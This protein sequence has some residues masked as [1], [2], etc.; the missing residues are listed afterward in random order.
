MSRRF[1]LAATLAVLL[2]ACLPLQALEYEIRLLNGNVFTSR[3]EPVVAPFDSTKLL[4][5]TTLGNSVAI[6]RDQVSEVISMTEASGFGKRIDAMTILI[7]L[8]PNDNPTPE[9][10]AA[11]AAQGEGIGTAVP[12]TMPL[13]GEPEGTGGIPLQFLNFNTPPIGGGAAGSFSAGSADVRRGGGG[14]QFVEP[15]TRD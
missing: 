9:E 7:G 15:Q 14:T 1:T 3:Y 8:A 10:E 6:S 12:Y 11:L 13:V 2:L 4:F 5:M